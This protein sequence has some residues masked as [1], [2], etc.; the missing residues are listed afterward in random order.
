MLDN[1]TLDTGTFGQYVKIYDEKL[2]SLSE[3]PDNHTL[4]IG[5]FGQYVQ[6]YDE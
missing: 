4:D 3:L 1:H 2:G 5:T 6:I